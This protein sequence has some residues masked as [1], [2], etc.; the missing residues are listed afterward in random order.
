MPPIEP[1]L[2]AM[3]TS[4]W[5]PRAE[6]VA[7]HRLGLAA[8][9][10]GDPGRVDVRGVDE[11]AAGL[12]VGVEH[13]ERLG[14]SDVQP[15]TLPPRHRGW[16][17]RSV[18]GIVACPRTY[19]AGGRS[20][21]PPENNSTLG[22]NS[23][24]EPRSSSARRAGPSPSA[25]RGF[26]SAPSI[27]SLGQVP[28]GDTIH[29]AAARIRP[30]LEGRVP[31]EIVTPHP[32]PRGG[33]AGR[34]GSRAARSSRSTPTASTCSS[35]F[36]GDLVLH[37]HLR[38]TGAW[39]VRRTASAGRARA[40][41]VARAARRRPRRRAVRR[42]GARAD[43]RV[44]R[45][46]RPA[47]SR[48]SAPTSSPTGSTRR[49][50]LRRL[51]EDD[52]TRGIGDA[53][54]DQRTIAGIG[55]IWK[56]EACFGA[57]IDPWRRPATSPTTRCW[58]SCA[59]RARACA[60][61][62]AAATR[63]DQRSTA[64]PGG[65]ARAAARRSA[66]AARATTTAAPTGARLPALSTAAS[67][68]RAPTS[69][70]P[71]TRWPAST[72]RWP[73]AWTWSSS[74]CCPRT[75]TAGAAVARPRLR[76]AR[77][78]RAPTLAE[79]LAHLAEDA[80]AGIELDVDMKIAGYE[81]RVV[82]ALREHGLAERA[83]IS[84]ME[85]ESLPIVRAAAPDIRLGWSVPKVRRNYLANPLTRPALALAASRGTSRRRAWRA[86]SASGRVDAIMCPPGAGHRRGW[87]TRCSAP[88]ASSTCGR[89]TT[90]RR[91]PGWPGSA[92]AGSSPTTRGCSGRL[93]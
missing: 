2:V 8:G 39:A 16:T 85:T 45:A 62:R 27:H 9:V 83:L 1:T 90:R 40:P 43:D 17:S 5:R 63:R 92:S 89:S 51:R 44:A 71:A 84:T 12:G 49:A 64:G 36:D 53:L 20:I 86:R 74:T 31:D 13:G 56:C 18:P 41:R 52:P 19:S 35:R 34:S 87:S 29:H 28:E 77:A 73:R 14:S 61:A 50:V 22:T 59:T 48:R 54:I 55:N 23:A 58:R 78:P 15:K 11:V 75:S 69:S 24:I 76:R 38:M 33:T 60:A 7:D 26:R 57:A 25:P 37:S 65:R 10:A 81:R 32:A 47:G 80:F 88:A 68:T 4:S 42:P 3:T 21:R 82:D 79:G 70:P 46:L 93:R 6:P 67:A 66:A 72:R 91:S 30:V